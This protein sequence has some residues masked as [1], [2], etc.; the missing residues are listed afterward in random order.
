MSKAHKL[1]SQLLILFGIWGGLKAS[2]TDGFLNEAQKI[3]FVS[4]FAVLLLIGVHQLLR[5]KQKG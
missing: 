1:F 4:S 3:V 2:F 5:Y